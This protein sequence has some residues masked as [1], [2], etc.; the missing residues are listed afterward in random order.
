MNEE[1]TKTGKES[2]SYFA[3]TESSSFVFVSC[4]PA[5]LIQLS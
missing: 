2:N 4:F 5:F 3:Q 1:R